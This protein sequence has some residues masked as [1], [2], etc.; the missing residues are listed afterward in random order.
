MSTNRAPRLAAVFFFSVRRRTF[1]G[2][3]YDTMTADNARSSNAH[4][5]APTTSHTDSIED[6]SSR[7]PIHLDVCIDDETTSVE[8]DATRH[9]AVDVVRFF[10]VFFAA[11]GALQILVLGALLS[12]SVGCTLGVVP[13]VMADRYARLHYGYD[14]A[15]CAQFDRIDKPDACQRGADE[16]QSAV[17]WSTFVQNILTLLSNTTIGSISDARGRKHIMILSMFLSLLSPL[18]LVTMQVTPSLDPV[19][20]FIAF[21]LIGLVNFMSIS[22]SMLSDIMPPHYRAPS[23]GLFISSWYLGFAGSP[24]LTLVMNH[25][26]VSL[27]SVFTSI[28]GFLFSCCALPETLPEAVAERNLSERLAGTATAQD[29]E[30]AL[31]RKAIFRPIRE[32]S[33]LNRDAM[34]RLLTVA[35]FFSGMVFSSDRSLVIFYIED[36]L[37]VRDGDLAAMMFIMAFVAI[38][39]QGFLI[40]P[41]LL[42]LGEKG[43]LV[44]SFLCG[45]LHNLSYGLARGKPLI[46]FALCL[47]QLTKTN[48]PLV[49]S[50]ASNNVSENE[51]GR[52]QGALFAVS[53]LA[54]A[55]GPV[56]LEIVYHYTKDG[57]GLLGPGTMWVFASFLYGIG[58]IIVCF[59]PADKTK[60]ASTNIHSETDLEERLL[61][62]DEA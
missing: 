38:V 30:S 25:F 18:V 49:S 10:S 35:Y 59:I 15:D 1:D 57:T 6:D 36:H 47:S 54:N 22:F 55:I 52:M 60:G 40:E 4:S 3:A 62:T 13:D 28:L 48:F 50:I 58:T 14:G 44:G 26:Q 56:L 12:F 46:Y 31:L 20:Y 23:F 16:A 41:L 2:D 8:E 61:G 24:S 45:T 19:W 51:Q 29:G 32:M 53:A 33:I 5:R 9:R 7:A 42:C 11:R 27:L 39:V 37:N 43:L 34:F 17:A 21:A